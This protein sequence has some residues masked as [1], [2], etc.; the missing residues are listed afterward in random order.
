MKTTIE[1]ESELKK[2]LAES[3]ACHK[4]MMYFY[5]NCVDTL[6]ELKSSQLIANSSSEHRDIID[7]MI[8]KY[9]PEKGSVYILCNTP[10][11]YSSNERLLAEIKRATERKVRIFVTYTE[12][13]DDEKLKSLE[14]I[15]FEKLEPIRTER[16]ELEFIT[17][18]E[19]IRIKP[20]ALSEPEV[21][22]CAP[23]VAKR[24][25]DLYM[26]RKYSRKE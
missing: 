6:F 7:E 22:P 8:F 12:S 25:I 5:R 17:N 14:N 2:L 4:E 19:A 21:I 3:E 20:D 1:Y 24:L 10:V 13:A 26:D 11:N 23:S 15:S 18:G 16:G 9:T